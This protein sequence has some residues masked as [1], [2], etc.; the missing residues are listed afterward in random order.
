MRRQ[1]ID[2]LALTQ[3]V[4]EI[5]TAFSRYEKALMCFPF[6]SLLTREE[7]EEAELIM[8]QQFACDEE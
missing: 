6:E 8:Q 2:R 7:M 4:D 5:M 3:N 1:E